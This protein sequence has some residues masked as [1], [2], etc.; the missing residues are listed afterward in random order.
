MLVNFLI[1]SESATIHSETKRS[2]RVQ[3]N[4]QL[5]S[6]R[7]R[8]LRMNRSV[9]LVFAVISLVVGLPAYGATQDETTD[10]RV[11]VLIER[12]LKAE[13]EQR[14]FAE[15]EALGCTAVPPMIRRMDD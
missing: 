3:L 7:S 15:L 4:S 10:M 13:T 6:R 14:A 5:E 1:T 8:G 9:L 12:M 2:S 11:A